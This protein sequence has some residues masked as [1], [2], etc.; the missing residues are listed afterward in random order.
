MSDLRYPIILATTILCTA[1][2]I[3]RIVHMGGTRFWR[4]AQV[5]IDSALIY[6]I[7]LAVTYPYLI[8]TDVMWS[9]P[10]Y[11]LE[12]ILIPISVRAC[13]LCVDL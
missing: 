9:M 12:S 4:S 10:E 6:A 11:I 5:V 13:H 2:I 7:L 3:F 1:L 8:S